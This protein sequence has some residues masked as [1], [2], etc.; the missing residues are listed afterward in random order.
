MWHSVQVQIMI[1]TKI[2]IR[3]SIIQD[4]IRNPPPPGCENQS[5]AEKSDYT[6]E[7]EREAPS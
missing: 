2:K 6:A 7:W 1:A 3:S 4:H 5:A